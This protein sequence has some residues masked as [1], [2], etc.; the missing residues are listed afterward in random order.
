MAGLEMEGISI[1]SD[2]SVTKNSTLGGGGA[3]QYIRDST[4]TVKQD[5]ITMAIDITIQKQDGTSLQ[6]Q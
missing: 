4:T 2:R 6:I 1:G 5:S 3:S